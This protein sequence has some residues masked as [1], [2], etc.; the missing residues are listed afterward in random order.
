MSWTLLI[1]L[2]MVTFFN[3]YVFLEPKTRI[4][5]PQFVMSMLNY[6]APCLMISIAMPIVFFD[7]HVWKGIVQN[8]YFYGAVF[9]IL[10][11]VVTR[12]L[13]MSIVT[14]LVFFYGLLYLL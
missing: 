3:R 4:V 8:S 10:M 14:S 13:L 11:T 7:H 12:K 5:V 9:C 2:A 1:G 6:A